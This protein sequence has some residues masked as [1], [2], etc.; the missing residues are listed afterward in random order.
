MTRI[1][2]FNWT[3]PA[4]L[5][6]RKH[7]T[8]RDWADDYARRFKANEVCQAWD[9]Q[10]RTGKGRKMADIRLTEKPHWEALADMPDSDY[11]EEG[12]KFFAE[13]PHLLPEQSGPVGTSFEYFQAWRLQPGGMWVVRLQLEDIVESAFQEILGGIV[14]KPEVAYV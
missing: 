14:P 10:P 4:L 9:H 8:R 2:S 11:E 5:A 3:T 1:I 7:C 13:H 12:F 6:D